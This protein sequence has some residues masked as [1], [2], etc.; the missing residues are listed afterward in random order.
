[1]SR[2]GNFSD[3]TLAVE[4]VFQDIGILERLAARGD[5]LCDDDLYLLMQCNSRLTRLLQVLSSETTSPRHCESVAC[6]P[7]ISLEK[8]SETSAKLH[9]NAA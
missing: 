5:R 4:S 7:E 1:M 8:T 2:L 9:V 3:D 6:T